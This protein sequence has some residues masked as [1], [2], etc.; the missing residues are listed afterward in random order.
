MVPASTDGT[1]TKA[2]AADGDAGPM[3]PARREAHAVSASP[4]RRV[5][6]TTLGN[7]VEWYDFVVYG[8]L[9]QEIAH[10]FFP[11]QDGASSLL[12]TFATFGVGFLARPVGAV[13]F[14][15]LGDVRGRRL[16][17]TISIGLM[18]LAS[19]MIGLAPAY[20]IAGLAGT[21]L[22]I[23]GRLLQGLSA[24]AEF[25][26]AISYLYE[27]APDRRKG[28]FGSFQQVGA[29]G[30]LLAGSM[31]VALLNALFDP[32]EM[33]AWGWRLA[34]IFGGILAIIVCI[35]RRGMPE[36]PHFEAAEAGE[37][38]APALFSVA[39]VKPLLQTIGLVAA[40][41]VS[42]FASIVYMST[43]TVRF[44]GLS[45]NLALTITAA[46][47]L[48]MLITI[49]ASG[50]LSDL[51]GRKPIILAGAAINLVLGLIGFHLIAS[52]VSLFLIAAIQIVLAFAG[53]AL[54]GVLPA[55][56]AGLYET[57]ERSTW[58]SFGA[59]VAAAMFGG[60]APFIATLLIDRTG[61]PGSP[62]WYV[63]ATAAL[64]IVAALSYRDSS[65]PVR[66]V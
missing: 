1:G 59:S 8:F 51:I 26:N 36:T 5:V 42:V 27:W 31:M 3:P 60:F 49:P 32:Q 65:R 18:A 2:L 34:F 45:P 10:N 23:V 44:G 24:G 46:A 15:R 13:V 57:R 41:T 56:I 40:W 19:L 48:V 20:A 39:V 14:G 7:V 38:A 43:F 29:C 12:S 58:T 11:S 35:L 28:L 52:G 33:M 30:G 55:A 6:V 53:G 64:T 25:G 16:A 22:V 37:G 61:I 54:S 63:A 4:V 21:L 66:P 47:T 50:M 17:L 62:G 9:V